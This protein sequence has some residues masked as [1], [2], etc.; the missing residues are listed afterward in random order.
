MHQANTNTGNIPH[1]GLLPRQVLDCLTC[2]PQAPRC[3][4]ECETGKECAISF[5]RFHPENSSCVL[6]CSKA[7]CDTIR[8]SIQ[9]SIPGGHGTPALGTPALASVIVAPILLVLLSGVIL[10]C[11]CRRRRRLLPNGRGRSS[12]HQTPGKPE[13][14]GCPGYGSTPG[15]V[16]G[17]LSLKPELMEVE[18][19]HELGKQ[20]NNRN[21]PNSREVYELD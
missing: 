10:F 19:P 6:E 17:A 8:S 2:S 21:L 13:L 16:A 9:P 7:F 11:Y 4:L 20:D 1:T 18:R 14:E 5:V 12:I 15:A 3:N